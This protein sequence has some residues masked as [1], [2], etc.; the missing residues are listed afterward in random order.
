MKELFLVNMKPIDRDEW[1]CFRATHSLVSAH[2]MAKEIREGGH[3]ANVQSIL[4]DEE[5]KV[6]I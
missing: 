4:I 3:Q 1:E 5:G 6:K 2:N